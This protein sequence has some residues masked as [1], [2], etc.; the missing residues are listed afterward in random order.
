MMP[1]ANF[2]QFAAA[3]CST[4][5]F[6]ILPTWYEYLPQ[7]NCQP[8]FKSL[9]DIWLILAAIIEILLRLA[10]LAAVAFV[11][12][13]G[14]MFTTSQGSPDQA[15]QARTTV[16]NALIGLAIAVT[17]SIFVAFLADKF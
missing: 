1:I 13:G 4:K 9:S 14:I 17:A 6:D 5:L 11:L 8:T 3:T 10:A 2:V 7:V 15:N 12:Y 16:I